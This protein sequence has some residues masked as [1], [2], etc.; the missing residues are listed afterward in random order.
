MTLANT[1]TKARQPRRETATHLFA[2]GQSVRPKGGFAKMIMP[3]D[4]Y[5]ITA[6]LPPRGNAL[7]YRI[8]CA[9]ERYDRV[10]AEDELEAVELVQA[11]SSLITRTFGSDK[12]EQ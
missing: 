9:E 8:R 11:D 2:V 6:T 4:V 10:M 7:Q 5:H 1:V 3:T 12:G